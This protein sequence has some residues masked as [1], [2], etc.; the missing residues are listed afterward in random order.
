MIPLCKSMV[1][2]VRI[3]VYLVGTVTGRG[4]KGF[5]LIIL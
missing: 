4:I 1:L 2:E 5:I 3:V